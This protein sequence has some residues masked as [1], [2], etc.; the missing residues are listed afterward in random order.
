MHPGCQGKY[1]IKISRTSYG[2]GL[3][4]VKFTNIY[5]MAD[6]KIVEL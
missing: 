5:S 6:I 3:H 1:V 4:L 2:M